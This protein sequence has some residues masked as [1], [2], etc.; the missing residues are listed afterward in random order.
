[1]K[2]DVLIMFCLNVIVVGV[3]VVNVMNLNVTGVATVKF[4]M[5]ISMNEFVKGGGDVNV[6][7]LLV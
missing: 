7:W 2:I 4:K 5:V 6:F 3:I 1:M